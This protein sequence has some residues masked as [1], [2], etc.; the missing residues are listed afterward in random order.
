MTPPMARDGAPA[1]EVP[2]EAPRAVPAAVRPAVAV[3]GV[4]LLL[5]DAIPP[6]AQN[7]QAKLDV[8][9]PF[10][11]K[12]R[13]FLHRQL[14]PRRRI[15][16]QHFAVNLEQCPRRLQGGLKAFPRSPPDK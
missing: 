10:E 13:L 2:D 9:R 5:R 6:L 1:R 12:R 8:V 16:R 15:E 11:T 14:R 7:A 3:A 4:A